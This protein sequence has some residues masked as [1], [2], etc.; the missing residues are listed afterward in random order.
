MSDSS[1]GIIQQFVVKTVGFV[2]FLP[3]SS[4]TVMC[5]MVIAVT[6]TSK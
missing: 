3:N 5:S 4:V 6:V 2:I 1:L